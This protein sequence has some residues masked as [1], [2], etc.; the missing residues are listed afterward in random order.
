MPTYL[1]RGFRWKRRSIRVFVVIQNLDDAA[2]EWVIKRGSARSLIEALY[3]LFDFLPEYTDP[4]KRTNSPEPR[5]CSLTG[6]SERTGGSTSQGRA[7]AAQQNQGPYYHGRNQENPTAPGPRR[8]SSNSSRKR[9]D[10][11]PQSTHVY[12]TPSSPPSSQPRSPTSN[13]ES[14]RDSLDP[15]LAQDWSPVKLLEEYDPNN[16]QEVSRP[17]AYVADYVQRVDSSCSIVEEIAKYE[18]QVRPSPNSAVTRQYSRGSPNGEQVSTRLKSGTGWLEQLRDQLQRDEEIQWYVV[19]NGDEERVWPV[20]GTGQRLDIVDARTETVHQAQY[21]NQRSVF[22]GRDKD[23]EM[24]RQQLR[25]EMG[26]EENGIEKL[27]ELR[28]EREPELPETEPPNLPPLKTNIP[29]QPVGASR[30][31]TPKTPGK[32]FRRLFGRSKTRDTS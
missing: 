30:P 25:K 10:P 18:Q 4:P 8:Q 5:S 32:A 7:A 26:Y 22:G 16:L 19:V 13:Y 3:S 1:C 12:H 17:Y 6:P 21:A 20:D 14:Q 31:K 27:V 15:V 9:R 2:P 29:V 28:P 23:I 11:V 24:R